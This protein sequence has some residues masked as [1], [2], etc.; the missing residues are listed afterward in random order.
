MNLSYILY[1]LHPC[2]IILNGRSDQTTKM[3]FFPAR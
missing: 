3:A 1:P 2:K